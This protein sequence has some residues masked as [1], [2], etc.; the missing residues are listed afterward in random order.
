MP[1]IKVIGGGLAG[2]EAAWQIASRGIPVHL[3]EMRP[4]HRSPAHRTGDLAELVCSNSL[5]SNRVDRAGG[6]LKAELKLA[7]S[8]LIRLAEE[9]SIPGGSSLCVDRLEYARLVTK[10]IED[11]GNI[12]VFRDEITSLPSDPSEGPAIIATGPLTSD[13]L[14][15]DIERLLGEGALAFYDAISPTI[16]AGS[17]DW[18]KVFIQDR[19]GDQ[20][21]GSYVNCPLQK[22]EY[23]TLVESLRTGGTVSPHHFEEENLFEACLPVE[24]LASRGDRTLAFGPMR[25]VGLSDPGTG[26]RP[27]AVVQLRPENRGRTLF[28]MVGF[29]TKLRQPEQERIFRMIPGLERAVFERLGSIHRNTFINAPALLDQFQRTCSA[30]WL[31]FAG[32]IT[33]VEGYV[34]SI[35]GGAMSGIYTAW[36]ILGNTPCP[37]PEFTM[38]GALLG[39][40]SSTPRG[41]FQPVNAQ[42]GLLPPLEGQRLGKAARKEAM[43]E[44]ALKYMR[45]YL[46]DIPS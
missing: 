6:L 38:I 37:P 25:P 43:A 16:E 24:V 28:G 46:A 15:A 39:R 14:A 8:L 36:E 41:G 3:Y 33:G 22:E 7:G 1:P 31:S 18:K 29:Q 13:A 44:R 20:E 11:N 23:L 9:A 27:Y 19:Y 2:C 40:L 45:A 4:L 32:Q 30:P 10:S 34:E 35:A 17:I 21:T 26:R 12:T 42:F 5:K